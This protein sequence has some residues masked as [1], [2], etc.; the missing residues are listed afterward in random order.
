MAIDPTLVKSVARAYEYQNFVPEI[1]NLGLADFGQ[2]IAKGRQMKR[3]KDENIQ[4]EVKSY[5]DKYPPDIP[6][7]K[8]PEK[9][10]SAISEFSFK[11]KKIYSDAV[12]S[13]VN[14][15][16]G[17]DEYQEQTD[18]MNGS[19]QSIANLKSQW[20]TFGQGKKENLGDISS[21]NYSLANNSDNLGLIAS[22]YTDKLD[23]SISDSGDLSFLTGDGGSFSLNDIDQPFLKASEEAMYIEQELVKAHDDGVMLS[24]ASVNLKMSQIRKVM[25]KGGIDS[26]KSLALDNLVANVELYDGSEEIFERI[27]SDDP[28]VSLEARTQLEN[29][30]LS[31]YRTSLISQSQTGYN[32]KNPVKAKQPTSKEAFN[33][34]ASSNPEK[35]SLL[36]SNLANKDKSISAGTE[37]QRN[38]NMQALRY[39][40]YYTEYDQETNSFMLFDKNEKQDFQDEGAIYPATP[41][42][43]NQ[44]LNEVDSSRR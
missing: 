35:Y 23:A 33:S 37:L 5:I 6:L 16:A 36:L 30:L 29:D 39:S 34:L 28:A 10:R 12:A 3:I 41:Q 21:G 38:L 42:G 11:Q 31:K 14:M 4:K 7:E 25:E 26:I 19:L 1:D 17:T 8:I 24:E 32:A 15:K 40:G 9:Y 27:D 18:L 22:V 43:I 44:L 20:D 2:K 13:R